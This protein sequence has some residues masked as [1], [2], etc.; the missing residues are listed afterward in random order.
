L[1]L[2]PGASAPG[3]GAAFEWL[4]LLASACVVAGVA[5]DA[6][7][8]RL[9]PLSIALA[10]LL[11]LAPLAILSLRGRQRSGIDWPAE[12]AVF[13][14]GAAVAWQLL[15][16]GGGALL[17][18]GNSVD[19]V[20]H[21][22]LARYILEHG[23]LVRD[24]AAATVQL[25]EM[26]DYPPGFALLAALL[27]GIWGVGAHAVVYPLASA[28]VVLTSCGIALLAGEGAP[29]AARPFATAAG[30]LLLLVP[31]YSLGIVAAENYYAQALAQCLIVACAY[32]AARDRQASLLLAASKLGLL[33][34]ALVMVY[35][36]WLPIALVAT[37]AG[38][39]ARDERPAARLLTGAAL[40][41]GA[42]AVAVLFGGARINTGAAV[43]L[44]EGSTIRDPLAETGGILP[45]L[46]VL[47]L[48]FGAAKRERWSGLGLIAGTL[49]LLAGFGV[50]WLRGVVASYIY[51][52][53]VYLL[54]VVLPLP[55]GW[56][57]AGAWTA[58]QARR[59]VLYRAAPALAV[60]A[61]LGG[62]VVTFASGPLLVST[63]A[64]AAHPLTPPLAEAVRWL[65]QHGATE[66]MYALRPGLPAYWVHIGLL[67]NARD[68]T[69]ERLL[70]DAPAS[71]DEWYY[72]PHAPRYL[73]LES[74]AAPPAPAGTNVGFSGDGVW[75]LEKTAAYPAAIARARAL[76]VSFRAAAAD[77][78]LELRLH[79]AGAA[80]Q[81]T[82]SVQLAALA[83]DDTLATHTLALPAAG[84]HYLWFDTRTLAASTSGAAISEAA[85]AGAYDV[86][87]RLLHAGEIIAQRQ[88]A[89]CDEGSCAV[90]APGGEW[91][92]ALP[93]PAAETAP[94]LQLGLGEA[95][96]LDGAVIERS[97]LKAGD[98]LR[99]GLRWKVVQA[100]NRRYVTFVQLIAADGGAAASIEGE[101]GSGLAPTWRWRAGDTIDD[102][103]R[104]PIAADFVPGRYQLVVGMYD[105]ASGERLPAWR[106]APFVERFWSGGLPLGEVV[107]ER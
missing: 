80:A 44:H 55:I 93:E 22:S 97:T 105:P 24:P 46:A 31:G 19:A 38:L 48:P 85:T 21:A 100:P 8:L 102:R 94:P 78:K 2:Q 12:L 43:M 86:V 3:L 30:L 15:A 58:L 66:V 13:L 95:I 42:T 39:L 61:A 51:L 77:G 101:P 16:P 27:A 83:G 67:G 60:V 106:R 84:D 23:A 49:L 52:K 18:V 59:P 37:G 62:A 57:V 35:T 103:W 99:L 29:S 79:V 32:V 45:L 41:G 92:Y 76:L 96:D 81:D 68:G 17:P 25:G 88:L 9:A 33:L 20:H 47:G 11:L 64:A 36:T 87:L 71:F 26:A 89:G 73:L 91:S 14:V 34:L 63:A 54:A 90:F 53:V 82:L 1:L 56:A 40:L 104:L 10:A 7:G 70:R 6:L 28:A 69:A 65:R 98:E 50:L 5:L 107:V 75:V 74:A 4:A 72:D